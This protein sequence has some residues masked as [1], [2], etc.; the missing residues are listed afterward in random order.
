MRV[1]K[2]MFGI[3]VL[4]FLSVGSTLAKSA[5]QRVLE[6]L[7]GLDRP[8][9][10]MEEINS[11]YELELLDDVFAQMGYQLDFLFMANDRTAEFI[12]SRSFD[13][14]A[15]VNEG[16]GTEVRHHT[17]PYIIYHNYVV[18][19]AEKDLTIDTVADLAGLRVGAFHAA[20]LLLGEAFTKITDKAY[21]YLEIANQLTKVEMLFKGRLD[22]IVIDKNLFNFLVNK[23]GFKGEVRYHNLFEQ[24]EYSLWM[25]NRRLI[26]LFNRTFEKY[27]KTEA[28]KL[29]QT[30]Y[31]IDEQY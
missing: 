29:L 4:V 7:V 30:N 17:R 26:P 10:V 25:A 31:D 11:G 2:T 16:L 28:Y 15:T 21:L 18:S 20:R 14:V 6:V 23:H 27:R 22:A 9:Y 5:D 8:P 12:K 13:V 3:I 19:L 1:I 24:T